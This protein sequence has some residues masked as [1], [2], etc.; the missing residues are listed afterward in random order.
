LDSRFFGPSVEVHL[1][2][3]MEGRG[4]PSSSGALDGDGRRSVYLRVR[5]N[6]SEPMLAAFDAPTPF[7]TIGR[8]CVSNVPAQALVLLNNE[9]VVAEAKRWARRLIRDYPAEPARVDQMFQT[10]FG[11]APA[12]EERDEVLK[13]I[14]DQR[15]RYEGA[16]PSD[17][18]AWEDLAHVL[19]NA[20]EFIFVQ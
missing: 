1:T 18:R 8:R 12:A 7:T 6:F 9:F 17:P 3:F 11:R 15:G 5:R 2:P 14:Q 16:D 19:L 13:F 4:R 10:A 20:K